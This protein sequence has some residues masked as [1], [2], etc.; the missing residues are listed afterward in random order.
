MLTT[1]NECIEKILEHEGGYVND[2]SDKGGE[3]KFGI[4]KRAYPNLDIKNLTLEKAILIYKQDYWY[5]NYSENLPLDIRYIHFD[6][7]VNMGLTKAAKIL[8]QSIGNI[9]VDG[10]IGMETLDNAVKS[11]LFKY[12]FYRLAYYNEIIYKDNSQV[13]FIGGWTK[14]VMDIVNNCFP[15]NNP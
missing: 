14:R 1:F 11:N 7:S 10:K 3:T 13:K 5:K 2:P 12:A 8:Q 4:S 6:T 15:K 9:T